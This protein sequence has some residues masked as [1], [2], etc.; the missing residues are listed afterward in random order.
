MWGNP[1]IYLEWIA[2][3]DA[4]D[5]VEAKLL[6][7]GELVTPKL[8]GAVNLVFEMNAD[9]L[10]GQSYAGAPEFGVTAAATYEVV[11]QRVRV[12]AE[13]RCIF[14]RAAFKNSDTETVLLVGPNATLRILGD[15]LKLYATIFV[16][17]TE[18]APRLAPWVI[19][20]SGW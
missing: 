17:V 13:A 6:L 1:V 20:A 4:P 14:E 9:S 12:G 19:L 16:G 18:D 10:K 3:H 11:A 7:G 2:N 15:H 8:L 5:R